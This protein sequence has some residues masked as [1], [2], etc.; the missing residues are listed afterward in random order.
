M[1]QAVQNYSK[2]FILLILQFYKLMMGT[3]LMLFVPQK[4]EDGPCQIIEL[5]QTQN[6][7]QRLALGVNTF[8]FVLFLITYA[9]ELRRERWLMNNF[10]KDD[11]IEP[12]NLQ[13]T[14]FHRPEIDNRL[15]S[16]NLH[17]IHS[18]RLTSSICIINFMSSGYF[19]YYR[20]L[21]ISTITSYASF[22]LLVWMKLYNSYNVGKK[23]YKKN[24]ALSAYITQPLAFNCLEDKYIDTEGQPLTYDYQTL[25]Q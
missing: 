18:L 1:K 6:F 24:I 17:Y 12:V 15:R 3:F 8:T 21:D 19:I 22:I 16:L 4:C 23:S 10:K 5:A 11:S 9:W 13:N 20:Y 7:Y 14:L 2:A 25:Q